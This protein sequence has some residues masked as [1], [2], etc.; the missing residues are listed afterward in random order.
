MA[1]WA[2]EK[3][4]EFAL[5]AT[6]TTIWNVNLETG[7]STT[8]RG[9][10]ESLFDIGMAEFGSIESFLTDGVHPDDR[11]EMGRLHRE[12]IQGNTDLFEVEFRTHPANGDVRWIEA[13]GRVQTRDG[14]RML[15]GISTEITERKRR[16]QQLARQNEQLEEITSTLAHDFRNPLHVAEGNL[17][18]ARED[19]ESEHLD[20]VAQAH[21]RLETLVDDLLASAREGTPLTRG[22]QTTDDEEVVDVATIAEQCWENVKTHNATLVVETTHTVSAD[23]QRLSQLFENLIRNAV[24]HSGPEVTVTIGDLSEEEGVYVADTGQGIP[25]D[26]RT[27]VFEKGYS[28]TESGTGFGLHIVKTVV[29]NHGWT[30]AVTDSETGGT[31]FEIT[32]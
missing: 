10:V 30:I 1:G 3:D 27:T 25:A 7:E 29:D 8:L 6:N 22:E 9:P 5:D 16:E 20:A 19:T 15:T 31:R 12:I 11:R 2:P 32:T 26:E 18:M 14:V 4:V 28:T 17:E 13:H 23:R 24:E 21:R